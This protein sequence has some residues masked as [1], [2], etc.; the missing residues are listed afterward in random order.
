[1]RRAALLLA[2]AAA[3]LAFAAP[4]PAA[5]TRTDARAIA[6]ADGR[7]FVRTYF[8][9]EGSYSLLGCRRDPGRWTCDL[10]ATSEAGI[11]CSWR[12]WIAPVRGGSHAQGRTH[13]DCQRA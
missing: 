13:V 4:A 6:R 9:T 2:T 12:L 7:D 3:A 8:R 10:D 5:V 11:Y 1:M